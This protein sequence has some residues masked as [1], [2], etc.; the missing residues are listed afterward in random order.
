LRLPLSARFVSVPTLVKLE[1]STLL[2]NVF[3]VTDEMSL[4]VNDESGTIIV[5]E[6]VGWVI[7][8]VV[9][10]SPGVDPL[11]LKGEPPC[12]APLYVIESLKLD[13]NVKSP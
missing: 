3:P 11:N 7:V 13:P 2:G 6:S 5:R 8:H 4:S 12:M 1:L 9:V 10:F